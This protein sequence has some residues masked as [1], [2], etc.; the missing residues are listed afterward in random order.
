MSTSLHISACLPSNE[1][2]SLTPFDAARPFAT[3][4]FSASAEAI[5]AQL[6]ER[7]L[8]SHFRYLGDRRWLAHLVASEGDSSEQLGVVELRLNGAG[9]L[10]SLEGPTEVRLPQANGRP[11]PPLNLSWDQVV[12]WCNVG[13]YVAFGANGS[14]GVAR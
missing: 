10:E 6:M 2:V 8:S 14:L 5:D 7:R 11:G 12:A 1:R 9:M 13:A 3:A 4:D